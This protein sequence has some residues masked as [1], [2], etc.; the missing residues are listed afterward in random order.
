LYQ[1]VN[2]IPSK[3]FKKR[4]FHVKQICT[5][6]DNVFELKIRIF[7]IEH[8]IN[9][10]LTCVLII[11]KDQWTEMLTYQQLKRGVDVYA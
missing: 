4:K 11:V 10:I 9:S 1:Q 5:F 2:F 6:V 8:S 7:T 3:F